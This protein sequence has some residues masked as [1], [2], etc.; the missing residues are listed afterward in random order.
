MSALRKR[1]LTKR[2]SVD[3]RCV[4]GADGGGGGLC[5]GNAGDNAVMAVNVEVGQQGSGGEL[6]EEA[7]GE[8]GFCCR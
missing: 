2:H 1:S 7:G 3:S 5:S 8:K 4:D 6:E